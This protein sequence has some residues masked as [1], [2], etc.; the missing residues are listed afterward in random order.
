MVFIK[1]KKELRDY[2]EADKQNY[3]RDSLKERLTDI[4]LG[5]EN[6]RIY[7]FVKNMRYVQYYSYK[8]RQSIIY[9]LPYLYYS[10]LYSNRCIH[11]GFMIGAT[12]FDKGLCIYH[13]GNI[14][15]NSQC[16]IGKN[17]KLHGSNCIG[18]SRQADDCPTIGDN[19]RLCVGAKVI[20]NIYIADGVTIAAGAVVTKS[21][22]EKNVTL[23]GIPA[24]VIKKSEET[25]ITANK[26][27]TDDL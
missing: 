6:Y 24:K 15:V 12:A 13:I 7:N 19:V 8:K 11:Y 25:I 5:R 3:L 18:N 26:L 21:C 16:K 10:L 23:A 20:G 27:Q 1:T 2:I 4:L 9:M 14:V 22:Y 17:C